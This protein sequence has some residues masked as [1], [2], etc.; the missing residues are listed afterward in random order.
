MRYVRRGGRRCY[1]SN[2]RLDF[3]RVVLAA[4]PLGISSGA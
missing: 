3:E 1:R 2:V 4:G